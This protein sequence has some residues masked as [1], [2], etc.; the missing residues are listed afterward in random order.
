MANS[1]N[2]NMTSTC[3]R[4]ILS[5]TAC[6]QWRNSI[7]ITIEWTCWTKSRSQGWAQVLTRWLTW[8]PCIFTWEPHL[9][10]RHIHRT[11]INSISPHRPQWFRPGQGMKHSCL[12][13]RHLTI[14]RCFTMS[15]LKGRWMIRR[16]LKGGRGCSAVSQRP[17]YFPASPHGF[18]LK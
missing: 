6:F 8:P 15:P 3:L 1:S 4:T 12:R 10:P 5:L 9:S 7:R 16:P 2:S 18:L 13:G 17:Y 11:R 14:I